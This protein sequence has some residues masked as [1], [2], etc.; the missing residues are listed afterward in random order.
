MPS[1]DP[2]QRGKSNYGLI[3]CALFLA[4]GGYAERLA[5]PRRS[6]GYMPAVADRACHCVLNCK[7][8][9]HHD[10]SRDVVKAGQLLEGARR[11]GERRAFEPPL[12]RTQSSDRSNSALAGACML[13]ATVRQPGRR[14]HSR[15]GDREPAF[16][17]QP[18][19]RTIAG[20]THLLDR[21]PKKS[22]RRTF[23]VP[24][25]FERG[26]RTTRAH[27]LS[28]TIPDTKGRF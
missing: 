2:S 15:S 16:C 23:S 13:R 26:G 5:R 22:S 6:L 14:S 3:A 1:G 18:I 24:N 7:I 27:Q 11:S 12:I 25:T 9:D 8:F 4:R 28:D 19:F 21:C 10:I 20:L 17:R